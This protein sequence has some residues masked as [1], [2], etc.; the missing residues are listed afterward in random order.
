MRVLSWRYQRGCRSL[1]DTLSSAGTGGVLPTSQGSSE[2]EREEE[3]FEVPEEVEEILGVVL[4]GLK[5][6]DTV[7]RWSAAKG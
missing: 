4:A 2:G 7:V 5:D 1:A 6:K 3:E